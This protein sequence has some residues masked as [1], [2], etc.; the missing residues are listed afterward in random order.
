MGPPHQR[1]RRETS[2]LQE[3]RRHLSI[4]MDGDETQRSIARVDELVW[5]PRRND[6]D[7]PSSG[8]NGCI[9]DRI[10]S[11]AFLHHKHFLVGMLVQLRSD[12]WRE[13]DHEERHVDI[14]V[15]MPLEDGD[16]LIPWK[17]ILIHDVRHSALLAAL[18]AY[19]SLTAL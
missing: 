17:L 6:H 3:G 13:V 10:R 19:G 7:L 16:M 12:A 4:R 15:L 2:L 9:G 1:R 18:V 5:H 14:A 8:L 11:F